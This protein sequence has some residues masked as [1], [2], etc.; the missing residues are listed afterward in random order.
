MPVPLIDLAAQ[1][2]A[3]ESDLKAAFE[4]VLQSGQFILGQEVTAFE[5]A[6]QRFIGAKHAI[7]VS[8]G[9]DAILLALMAAGIGPGDDVLC[10]SFTFFATAGCI[11]RVGARPVFVDSAL[12]TFNLDVDDAQRR[13]TS[14][15]KAIIP[16][17]LYGQAAAMDEVMAFAEKHGLIVIE[18][19]AQSLGATH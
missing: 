9:T 13:I 6:M 8:S 15:T 7:G 18:D 4:R 10:P 3:L 2:F 12:D 19:S 11:S 17:H 5:E 16:V 1:N 14:A